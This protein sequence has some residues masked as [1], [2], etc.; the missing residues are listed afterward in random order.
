MRIEENYFQ[1]ALKH[2]NNPACS[3]VDEFNEDLQKVSSLKRLLHKDFNRRLFLNN[4]VILYNVFDRHAATVMLFYKIDKEFWSTLKTYLVFLD[5][6]P[7]KIE[8]LGIINSDIPV[9]MDIA[10]ELRQL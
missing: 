6:M 3:T 1:F 2:Y 5:L 10:E 7:E 9:N 4:L 8:E